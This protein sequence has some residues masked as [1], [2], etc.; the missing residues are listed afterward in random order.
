[1]GLPETVRDGVTGFLVKRRQDRGAT[2]AAVAGRLLELITYSG[3]RA[4]MG[5]AGR[6]RV[7]VEFSSRTAAT[8][9]LGVYEKALAAQSSADP[10]ATGV[11]G[12][13]RVAPAAKGTASPWPTLP[14]LGFRIDLVDLDTAAEWVVGAARRREGGTAAQKR[15][16]TGKGEVSGGAGPLVPGRTAVA[17]SFNPELVMRARGRPG[18]RRDPSSGRSLLRRRGRGGLGGAPGG[19]DREASTRRL[20]GGR[21]R[22]G[23]AGAWSSLQEAG[24]SVYFLGAKPGVADEAAR[25]QAAQIPGLCIAGHRD[26]YFSAAEEASV[27]AEVRESGADILFV[28]MGAPRQESLLFD[29]RDEWGAG[30]ALGIGGSFDVWA[31]ATSRAPEWVRK[32][33]VEWLYRLGREPKRLRR[34][35][36][37]PRYAYRVMRGGSA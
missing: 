11:Q 22:S 20:Q 12:D 7:A 29:H 21:H 26:G 31:G 27:V 5:T 17:V 28:A 25:R 32:A 18:G 3:M 23:A 10:W 33:G 1:M 16:G 19:W 30:V 24:L 4:R 8:T 34:Q 35:A 15:G 14:V 6:E 2:I 13:T 9:M 37:L 36:A